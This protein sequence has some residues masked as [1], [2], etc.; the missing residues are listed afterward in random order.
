MT[1]TPILKVY[2]DPELPS[3]P[4][5]WTYGRN[6]N[7]DWMIFRNGRVVKVA[8]TEA[9]LREWEDGMFG[10]RELDEAPGKALDRAVGRL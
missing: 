1:S 4:D 5:V 3:K 6:S 10:K 8:R 9:E 2:R 7:N